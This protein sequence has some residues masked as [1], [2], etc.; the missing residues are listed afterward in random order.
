MLLIIRYLPIGK[1]AKTG[2][3]L[4]ILCAFGVFG[5]ELILDLTMKDPG[6]GEVVVYSQGSPVFA[7]AG[8]AVGATLAVI[9]ILKNALGRN[10]K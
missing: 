2:A 7:Y 5:T 4:A 10:R 8:I 1:L 6:P 3:V 9:G